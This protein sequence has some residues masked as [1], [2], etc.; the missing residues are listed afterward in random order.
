[1]SVYLWKY[2]LQDDIDNFRRVLAA[3]NYSGSAHSRGHGAGGHVGPVIGSP[4]QG[5]T[6][7]PNLQSKSRGQSEW[8]MG[9]R[10]NKALGNISLTRGD[11]NSRDAH[12]VTLLHLM[13]SSA[14]TEA[15]SY[16]LAFLEIPLLDLYVQ[17]QESGWTALHRA[18]YFGN[19]TIARALID[20]D[21]RDAT[22]HASISGIHNAGG[23]IKIKDREGNSP[24]DVFNATVTN[25]ILRHSIDQAMIDAGNDDDEDDVA[26]G[27]GVDDDDGA[28]NR[29][30]AP[31]AGID[32]DELYT[33]GSNKNFTL[34]FGDEDDRQFPE[35]IMLKRPEHLLRRLLAEHQ[36]E[37]RFS[38]PGNR[39]FQQEESETHRADAMPALVQYRPIKILDV[40][41]SK[42]HTA[43]LT[44]D[45]EANLYVCGFGPGGRLGTGDQ[46]TRFAF[47]CVYGG[48]LMNKKIVN[49]GLGQNHSI[50]VCSQ[51]EVFSWGTNAFGQL[52]YTLP[53]TNSKDQDPIQLLPRQIFGPLKREIVLGSAASRTHSVV[54]TSTSLYTF[55]KNDGQ[56]GLVDSDARSLEIQVT[57][58]KV[59]ASLFSS[60]IG[61]V[62]AIDKATICLLEN[63]D[64]WVFANYGW[65]KV[66]FP[67][68]GFSNYFL[69]SSYSSTRYDSSPN[70]I[71]KISSGGDTICALARSGDVFTV[72]VSQ[73]IESSLNTTSTTNPA[74]IRGALS[75]PQRIWSLRKGHMAVR[76]VD[77]GQDGSVIICTDSGSVWKRVKRA[78]IKDANAAP[79]SLEYKPKDYKFSRIGGLT[80]VT[81]VRSN[82]FGAF[83]AVRKDSDVLRSQVEVGSNTLWTNI[84]PLLSFHALSREEDSDTE[85]P[86][87]RYWKPRAPA[88]DPAIIRHAVLTTKA[89]EEDMEALV[90]GNQDFESSDYDVKIGTTVSEVRIPCHEFL[91]GGRSSVLRRALRNFRQSYYFSLPEV[92]TIEYDNHGNTL[93]LFQ[94]LDFITILNLVLYSYT[95]SIVDVWH[96]TRHAPQLV[97]RYRQVRT[98]LMKLAAHLEMRGLESAARLMTAP[99]R[100]LHRD[101]EL[102]ILDPEYFQTGDVEVELEDSSIK[103]H[104]AL[105]CQR[106]PFFE[107]LFHGRAGGIW[108][109]SRRE[110]IQEQQ[111]AIKVDMK[112]AGIKVFQLVLR[113]IYADTGEELF[114]DIVTADFDAFLDLVMDVLSVANE[115]MLDR[116]AQVCQKMLGR[117]VNTRNVCQLL[118]AVAPCSVTEFKDAALEYICLNLEGMLENHLLNELDDDLMLELDEVVRQNQLACLPFAKS[119]RAE[120]VLHERHSELAALLDR[121]K[122]IK[123]DSM[124]IQS[125]LHEHE[126]KLITSGKSKVAA[127]GDAR[128]SS[129][130]EPPRPGSS[131]SDSAKFN[132]PLLK[133]RASTNDLMFDMDEDAGVESPRMGP[134]DRAA[135]RYIRTE[136][137]RYDAQDPRT[138]VS[139]LPREEI[140]FD[141]RGKALSPPAMPTESDSLKAL[142]GAGSSS[143][144]QSHKSQTPASSARTIQSSNDRAPWKTVSFDPPKLDLR[145]IMAQTPS[146]SPSL[147][148][149]GLSKRAGNAEVKVGAG[150]KLS[151][152]ERKKQ[153]QQQQ[154]TQGLAPSSPDLP[155]L[156]ST[157]NQE[158]PAS[159]WRTASAG[160]RI[161]LKDVLGDGKEPAPEPSSSKERT[162]SNPPLTLRQTVPGNAALAKRA[163]SSPR[164]A[165]QA[166]QTRSASSPTITNPNRSPIIMNTNVSPSLR[167]SSHPNPNHSPSLRPSPHPNLHTIA[168]SPSPSSQP[169]TSIRH[170]PLGPEP[171]LPL[172]MAD[173]LAQQQTEKDILHEAVAPRSLQEIQEEQAFQEWWDKEEAA[174]RAL[175]EAE[176][177]Q[178]AAR[179]G[180]R[181]REPAGRAGS[182]RAGAVSRGGRVPSEG[183]GRGKGA[184]VGR[185]RGR[186][187]GGQGAAGGSAAGAGG[188][189]K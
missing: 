133:A 102:A 170:T 9:A 121:G 25:R 30:I 132:S 113:H 70:H 62:S 134:S 22:G 58:R 154:L 106:C 168:P 14:A 46:T 66:T 92:F 172:S 8:H 38:G 82:T 55:G 135:N 94:G 155:P 17:D 31:R 90:R 180:K 11:V 49:I 91:L 173:I 174:T 177:A 24:F 19:T 7:S 110:T 126:S 67:L 112:H 35:R 162:A 129:N 21:T 100:D 13:A 101:M 140:W 138:P 157:P 39:S 188:A 28:G 167:P 84:F 179:G 32:G 128:R 86:V 142:G 164:P 119:G 85:E 153:L 87:L 68:D 41:L 127:A 186:G 76:D 150:S 189:G 178:G 151:Q 125:R 23:L 152:K 36:S 78:K 123:V 166:P 107:G 10:G 149:S 109:S 146:P 75:A 171:A 79:G 3:A 33:F 118:N 29:A 53:N 43:V 120:A 165:P 89:L 158:K 163:I 34:G 175:L 40:Q 72:T 122:R 99:S 117:F 115:L 56:L 27:S 111:E 15:P 60:S 83:A 20:R 185:G 139:S 80:R 18:L 16:A 64:V 26:H 148:T 52:G 51:G 95:D 81:A 61:M 42:F 131:R 5:L 47:I 108:L 2:Y 116:L 88:D 124:A 37:A 147:L 96:H 104:S 12:G 1:M 45:P 137:D 184:G 105:M 6:T 48:G 161:N 63:R 69:K 4:G 97:F 114:D 93:I 143:Q 57:P 130:I 160:P 73:N 156:G 136:Q 71:V 141:S 182:G 169:I 159:P 181:G 65:K 145:D 77:V 59:A 144:D 54:Y 74:K 50:A 103:V 98:E 176:G 44:T 183:R 187:R